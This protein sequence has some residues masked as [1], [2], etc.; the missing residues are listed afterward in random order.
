ML[1]F[2]SKESNAILIF[3][4]NYY[5]T[6]YIYEYR[7]KISYPYLLQINKFISVETWDDVIW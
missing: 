2:K 7:G 6:T 1:A 5:R 4:K 3:A